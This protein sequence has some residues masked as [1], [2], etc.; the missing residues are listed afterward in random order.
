VLVVREDQ[1]SALG[2]APV[3]RELVNCQQVHAPAPVVPASVDQAGP[4]ERDVQE[5]V[6]GRESVNCPPANDRVEG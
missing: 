2:L 6:R 4:E 1:A 3:G 5:L